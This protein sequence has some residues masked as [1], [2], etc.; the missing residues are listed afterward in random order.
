MTREELLEM[1]AEVNKQL[2][3]ARSVQANTNNLEK[4]LKI[5]NLAMVGM[6]TILEAGVY[7]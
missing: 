1:M 7:R 5:L 6:E 2:T 3:F 4:Q